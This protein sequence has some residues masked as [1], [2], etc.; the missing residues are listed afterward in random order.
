MDADVAR[1]MV[2]PC[3]RLHRIVSS[4]NGALREEY[5]QQPEKL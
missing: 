4:T 3:G 2:G 1:A 5:T